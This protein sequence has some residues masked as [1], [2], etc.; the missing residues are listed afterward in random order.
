MAA[1]SP[2]RLYASAL[3]ALLL[4]IGVAGFFYS[5][6]TGSPGAVDDALGAFEVNAW[7]N[8]L[9]AATGALGLFAASYAARPFA[10]LAGWLY[11]VLAVWGF[12][13]GA[14]DAILGFLPANGGDNALHLV[15]GLLGLAAA[16][17]TSR[18]RAARRL[19][20]R[21]DAAGEG[22]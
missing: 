7:L 16:A 17:G 5:A 9:H 11:T 4:V 3:G 8:L 19:E 1:P 14:G 13:L 15:V 21:A 18:E 20:P 6:S 10:L 2:S 22:A 12:T